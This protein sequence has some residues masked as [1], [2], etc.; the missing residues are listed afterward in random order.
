[1][2]EMDCIVKTVAVRPMHKFLM[3]VQLD[4]IRENEGQGHEEHET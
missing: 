4:V 1:M 3:S 2:L